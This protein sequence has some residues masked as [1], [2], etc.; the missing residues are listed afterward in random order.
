MRTQRG[1]T[2][3][4]RDIGA[5]ELKR[6]KTVAI[7]IEMILKRKKVS[8]FNC[9]VNNWNLTKLWLFGYFIH[10]LIR[11]LPLSTSS[12]TSRQIQMM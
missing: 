6:Q 10:V 4:G 12:V 3:A 9:T 11:D 2:E 1:A 7:N 5:E 8:T